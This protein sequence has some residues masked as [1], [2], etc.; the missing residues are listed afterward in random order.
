VD[1]LIGKLN[2]FLDTWKKGRSP[3]EIAEAARKLGESAYTKIVGAA[4]GSV[5]HVR[6]LEKAAEAVDGEFGEGLERYGGSLGFGDRKGLR[7]RLVNGRTKEI[8]EAAGA[9]VEARQGY[10]ERLATEA[11]TERDLLEAIAYAK[12]QGKWLTGQYGSENLS[13]EQKNQYGRY[14]D[15]SALEEALKKK[16]PKALLQARIKIT[17]EIFLLGAKSADGRI[18]WGRGEN[19]Y[20]DAGTYQEAL[21]GSEDFNFE[22]F[23]LEKGYTTEEAKLFI[24]GEKI[25]SPELSNEWNQ[26]NATFIL[27]C[28]KK[29]KEAYPPELQQ[30]WTELENFSAYILDPDKL[31]DNPF[32]DRDALKD[33]DDEAK[34]EFSQGLL[35]FAQQAHWS[36]FT[37]AN[38]LRK[39][40][41]KYI[42]GTVMKALRLQAVSR[43]AGKDTREPARFS[44]EM[45]GENAE[46]VVFSYGPPGEGQTQV[47]WASGKL[48]ND[49]EALRE[50]ERAQAAEMLGLPAEALSEGWMRSWRQ[51][52]DLI[53]KGTFTVSGEHG[54]KAG[55]Y[56]VDYD[57]NDNRVLRKLV[58]K[59]VGKAD[60][61]VK[62]RDG[63][64][65]EAGTAA[66]KR[67]EQTVEERAKER[68]STVEE[69]RDVLENGKNPLDGTPF[70]YRKTPPLQEGASARD[71]QMQAAAWEHMQQSAKL[72][73]WAW[74]F[75]REAEKRRKEGGN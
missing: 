74:Y 63:S 36:G 29:I 16:T 60:V 22:T 28:I 23:L 51:N 8:Q 42:G 4:L 19:E 73:S 7:E 1:G 62:K 34:R 21:A 53:P 33:L 3:I 70:D 68:T 75:Q 48:R 32:Y 25:L 35:D 57:S 55:T 18:Y 45:M 31:K 59:K 27:S 2:L 9:E 38:D 58:T 11:S 49:A 50:S 72:Q 46:N 44:R 6:D 39:E 65:W 52:D 64:G 56:Y 61:P 67:R 43:E 17:P 10:F 12:A 5:N 69:F 47:K 40:V 66:L 26:E 41:N 14:F 37:Q 13:A 54:E 20:V 30:F 15:T 71:R 24:E